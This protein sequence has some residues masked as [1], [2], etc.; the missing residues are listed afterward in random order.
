M[1][2]PIP[3]RSE[4]KSDVAEEDHPLLIVIARAVYEHV[5]DKH[6]ASIRKALAQYGRGSD[7]DMWIDI[8]T[9][10]D[11]DKEA[12]DPGRKPL[13]LTRLA[14]AMKRERDEAAATAEIERERAERDAAA[15]SSAAESV[16]ESERQRIDRAA[17][18]T[19]AEAHKPDYQD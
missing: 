9:V 3:M 14:E 17:A 8:C 15:A 13:D 1:A 6:K 4:P 18:A 2:D 12:T 11:K 7:A 19:S 16:A 10:S 5:N